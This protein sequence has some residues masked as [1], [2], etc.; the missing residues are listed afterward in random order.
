MGEEES[1]EELCRNQL[2]AMLKNDIRKNSD[3]PNFLYRPNNKPIHSPV[4]NQIRRILY[5]LQN[6]YFHECSSE[7][8]RIDLPTLHAILND[9]PFKFLYENIP[10]SL[11]VLDVL[12]TRLYQTTS[13]GSASWRLLSPDMLVPKLIVFFADEWQA[14]GKGE[15]N[16]NNYFPAC[17]NLIWMASTVEKSLAEN[18]RAA[19]TAMDSNIE[20]LGRHGLVESFDGS[21]KSLKSSLQTEMNHMVQ[22]IKQALTLLKEPQSKDTANE[23]SDSGHQRLLQVT[24]TELETRIFNN[25][26]LLSIIEPAV[27]CESFQKLLSELRRRTEDDK[28]VL[29]DLKSLQRMNSQ[30]TKATSVEP[31]AVEFQRISQ[32]YATA[33]K[34]LAEVRNARGGSDSVS[35][36][37]TPCDNHELTDEQTACSVEP[38]SHELSVVSNA[39]SSPEVKLRDRARSWSN[40][41]SSRSKFRGK[42]KNCNLVVSAGWQAPKKRLSRRYRHRSTLDDLEELIAPGTSCSSYCSGGDRG[43]EINE[44]EETLIDNT[45]NSDEE[46]ED[47]NNTGLMGM[48]SRERKFLQRELHNMRMELEQSKETIRKLQEREKQLRDRLSEQVQK[49]FTITNSHFEDLSLNE[50]R[51]TELIRLYGNLYSETRVEAA[52]DLDCLPQ[53]AEYENLKTKILFSVVVLAF[54]ST[55]NSLLDLKSKVRDLLRIQVSD[56]NNQSN[57]LPSLTLEAEIDDYIRKTV[58]RHDCSVNAEEVCSQIYMTLYDYPSLR[59]SS[60]LRQYIEE[61]IRVSWALNVQNPRYI[62]SYDSRT[63][64]PNFH[65]RFHTSDSTSDDILEFLWPTLLEGNSSCCVFKGVVIT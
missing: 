36:W 5:L 53:V 59:Q 51:P 47:D 14:S 10:L 20:K 31:V 15:K 56:I 41:A 60:G 39:C 27:K 42:N 32:G 45:F 2:R 52:D 24:S 26:S 30:P 23:I 3:L 37:E 7:L 16:C 61:C 63:F 19:K 64:N 29:R 35:P 54:R 17:R 11:L 49:Q 50:K 58:D 21:L 57:D 44:E 28:S 33:L 48:E 46:D 34:L 38:N 1:Y 43:N 8:K 18:L 6:K 4:H 22:Q 25:T 40:S 55:L 12:Y 9:I 13:P 62:I 65:S